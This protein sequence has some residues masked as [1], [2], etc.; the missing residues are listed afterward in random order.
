MPAESN[1]P[2]LFTINSTSHWGGD[3]ALA[4]DDLVVRFENATYPIRMRAEGTGL[5]WSAPTKTAELSGIPSQY[6]SVVARWRLT[7][8][9]ELWAFPKADL[10][11]RREVVFAL[12]RSN[13]TALSVEL[14]VSKQPGARP[15]V[16]V[17]RGSAGSSASVLSAFAF[18]RM[19]PG[20]RKITIGHAPQPTAVFRL[21]AS[22]ELTSL[23]GTGGGG[24][25]TGMLL[26]LTPTH[27]LLTWRAAFG[28]GVV[29][30]DAGQD[31]ADART[32]LVADGRL[33]NFSA[34]ATNL[35]I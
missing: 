26:K 27:H 8:D 1:P 13:G 33:T 12:D 19:N 28:C 24:R 14:G 31:R 34:P 9:V 18:P 17:V 4:A 23:T 32:L 22:G 15:Q 20:T 5:M 10:G 7:E 16:A 29:A 2:S 11:R 21:G 25:A 35:F 6:L 30:F 3:S